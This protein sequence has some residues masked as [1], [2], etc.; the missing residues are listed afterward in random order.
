MGALVRF[1]EIM[2]SN[3]NAVLDKLEDPS[4]MIDQILRNLADDLA[5]VREETAGVIAEE[6]RC[7]RKLAE[8]REEIAKY[9]NLAEQAVSRGEDEDARVFLKKKADLTASL[10]SLEEVYNAAAENSKKM[11]AMHDKLVEQIDELNARREAIKAKVAVAKTQ[12]RINKA[13]QGADDAASSISAFERMEEKADRMLDRANAAAEL[14]KSTDTKIEDLE[15][16][17]DTKAAAVEDELAALKAK[18]GK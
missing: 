1:K 13:T 2:A 8:C 12:E 16:K 7:A 4:K 10:T 11:K 5:E 18:L 17:Y 14:G 15:K 3:I 6:Q 9:Q